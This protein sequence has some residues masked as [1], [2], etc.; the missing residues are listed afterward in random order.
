MLKALRP[1]QMI[2]CLMQGSCSIPLCQT[3]GC[4]RAWCH[5]NSRCKSFQAITQSS[6]YKLAL[7]ALIHIECTFLACSIYLTQSTYIHDSAPENRKWRHMRVT[8]VA[9]KHFEWQSLLAVPIR[10]RWE[11][12][13]VLLGD[14][15]TN[16]SVSKSMQEFSGKHSENFVFWGQSG[17]HRTI[18]MWF[19]SS[20]SSAVQLLCDL[21][22]ERW[23]VWK[24]VDKGINV[25][26]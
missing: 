8:L 16:E 20:Q 22:V 7:I 25:I 10:L 19:D 6:Q 23:K 15:W 12:S 9:V 21:R 14:A 24:R 11:W 4:C 18:A 13:H 1:S 17:K 2:R 3:V 5:A 26:V